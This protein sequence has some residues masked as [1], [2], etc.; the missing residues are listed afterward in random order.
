MTC[1]H[2]RV[3]RG[4]I[5][6]AL[7]ASMLLAP[8]CILA[9]VDLENR[10]CP[11]GPG[12]VCEGVRNECVRAG[13]DTGVAQDGGLDASG[14][15]A[16]VDDPSTACDDLLSAAF[17]CEP[18]EDPSLVYWPV[19]ESMNGTV[20]QTRA[21][22]FRGLG[23]LGAHTTTAGGH[24]ERIATVVGS[25][26]EGDI[27]LRAY[28]FIEEGAVL[29]HANI[30]HIGA[31]RTRGATEPLAG[32]NVM[33]GFASMYIGASN[34]HVRDR[35]VEVP[36][37]QWFCAQMMVHVDDVDGAARLWIDDA[38][39]GELVGFDTRNEAPYESLGAGIGWSELVQ[40]PLDVYVDELALSRT[41]LPCGS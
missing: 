13:Q 25:L 10:P 12:W 32:F 3:P 41:R 26:S 14:I 37:G 34:T 16:H 28:V 7:A 19:R 23:A 8:S 38:L 5:L 33:E 17:F 21:R 15:D 4:S 31:H 9:P 11:C 40:E 24:A 22:A 39:A 30:L 18:F 20:N 35:L 27:Y 1:Y 29:E 2:G 6:H 36:R